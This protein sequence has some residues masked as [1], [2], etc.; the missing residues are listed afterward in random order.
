M[1]KGKAITIFGLTLLCLIA[2][3]AIY[4]QP[5]KAQSNMIVVPNDYSTIQTAINKA[6]E[7]DTI[8]V[9][10]GIYEEQELVL[11]KTVAAFGTYTR[12]GRLPGHFLMAFSNTILGSFPLATTLSSTMAMCFPP[13]FLFIL[14]A[15]VT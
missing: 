1:T 15:S 7:G 4:L 6:A 12:T 9:K 14:S 5:V 2:S 13:Y 8:F 10:T 11:N 3:S